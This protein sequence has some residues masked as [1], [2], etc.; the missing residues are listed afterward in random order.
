MK[1]NGK[2]LDSSKRNGWEVFVADTPNGYQGR[3]NHRNAR[4]LT[5]GQLGSPLRDHPCL[6]VLGSEERGLFP[7]IKKKAD[8][9]ITIEGFR[10]GQAGVESLNVSVAAGL[11]CNAFL[12]GS[13][14]ISMPSLD[15]ENAIERYASHRLF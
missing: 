11:L 9:F 10:A 5:L 7:D 8:R 14:D 12:H 6:L 2:F 3:L 15:A 1:Q 13:G 4:F